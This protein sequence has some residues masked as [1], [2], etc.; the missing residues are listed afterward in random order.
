[1]TIRTGKGE[2]YRYYSCN[3]RPNR[4][5]RSCSCPNVRTE[6]LDEIVMSTVAD[7]VF[8]NECLE[9]LLQRILDV[10][11]GARERKASEIAQC[12]ERLGEARKRLASLHD[13]IELGTLSARDPDVAG[14][15]KERR[16]EI[17]GLNR[18]MKMLRQQVER[19][20]SRIT[21]DA[22]QRFGRLIR[23]RL[24]N[25]EEATRQQIARAF[26]RQVRVGPKT[27][28]SMERRQR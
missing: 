28:K 14:R 23:E 8:E 6:Q 27:S 20:P 17:D 16:S 22:V 11:D 5:A 24:L 26:I 12:E 21:P 2:W 19:I 13:G 7:R 15:I 1:M 18:T 10:S 3:A 4:G 9:T 25:G